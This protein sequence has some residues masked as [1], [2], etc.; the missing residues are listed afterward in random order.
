MIDHRG[1]EFAA[2][3]AEITAGLKRVFKTQNDV[4]TLTASGSGGLEA[5]VVNLLSPGERAVVVSIGAFGD[6]FATIARG[7]G[8]S[9]RHLEFEW[10]QAA[11]P[12]AIAEVLRE[13]AEARVVFVTHNETS[14]GVTNDLARIAEVVKS[15][16]RLLVV[17]GVS[18]VSSIDLESDRW[19]CDVVVSG[20]QKGW[21]VPPGLTFASVSQ[22]AWEAQSRAKLPRFYFD[23]A[24]AKQLLAKGQTPY[25]PAISIFYALQA[26]LPMIEAEGLD[27]VFARHQRVAAHARAGVRALGL[28]PFAD[29]AVASATVTAVRVPQGVDSKA[30]LRDLRE[31]HTVALAGGQAKLEG[32]VFRIGHLGWVDTA[33]IDLV[34]DALRQALP[35]HGH[36]VPTESLVV[37]SQPVR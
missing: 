28:E 33:D 6:R 37:R 7:Y 34:L 16:G 13:E 5:A 36:H 22:A 10:G 3:I 9:V 25:T 29:E 14:T 18:S 19:G 8:A 24:A 1:P 12:L 30:L 15:A 11:D 20:S 35:R 32:Q 26:T 21:M 23:L 17:D 31:N 27:N 4:L 2:L